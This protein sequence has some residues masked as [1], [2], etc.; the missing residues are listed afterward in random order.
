MGISGTE[1]LLWQCK[2]SAQASHFGV[3]YT[4]IERKNARLG[5]NPPAADLLLFIKIR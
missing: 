1:F 3:A 2:T 5:V 4:L